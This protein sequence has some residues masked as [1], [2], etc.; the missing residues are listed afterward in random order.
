MQNWFVYIYYKAQIMQEIYDCV[1]TH[2]SFSFSVT[3]NQHITQI[4]YQSDVDFSLERDWNI[5]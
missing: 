1:S 5:Q 2:V 4:Y 3:Q